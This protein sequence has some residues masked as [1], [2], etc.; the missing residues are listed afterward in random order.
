MDLYGELLK[1]HG[2][3]PR[4]FGPL[5]DATLVKKGFNPLCGDEIT[6]FLNLDGDTIKKVSFTGKGCLFFNA[7]ASL[8]TQTL[9]GKTKDDAQKL[10]QDFHE[11]MT[12]ESIIEP[13]VTKMGKLAIFFKLRNVPMRVK[14][15]TL[16]WHT[17]K[18]ALEEKDGTVTTE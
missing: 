7:S 6:V 5:P 3:K 16:C 8:M 14:C 10:F 9:Q 11:M 13:D 4:N 1:D 15:A 2:N 17:L 12:V 18:A